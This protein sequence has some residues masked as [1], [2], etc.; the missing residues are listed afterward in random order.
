MIYDLIVI[1]A[2]PGGISAA[3]YAR[4]SNLKVLVLEKK[5]PGGLVNTTNIVENYA[6]FTSISGPDLAENFAEHL[7]TSEA[8][9]KTEEVIEVIDGEIKKVITDSETYLTKKVLVAVGREPKKL[10]LPNEEELYGKGISYC[11]ICDAPLF[12]NKNVAIYG[13]GNSAFEEGLYLAKFAKNVII[14]NRSKNLKAD[15][16]LQKKA[17]ETSNIKIIYETTITK[18]NGKD[19]LE[20]VEINNDETLSVEGLFIYIGYVPATSFLNNLGICD[21]RGYIET[22]KNL[23]TKVKGIYAVGDVCKKEVYQIVTAVSEGA[24]AAINVNNSLSK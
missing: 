24:I 14:L 4:R 16:I 9:Y 1:G 13:G 11:C 8:E 10:K 12:K 22:D 7:K 23:E 6:G 2:G 5:Y 3:I 19:Y 18:I 15:N 21:E 17:T 20:S